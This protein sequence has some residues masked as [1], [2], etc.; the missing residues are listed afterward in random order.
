MSEK[1]QGKKRKTNK[2]RGKTC[3]NADNIRVQSDLKKRRNKQ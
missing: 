2:W 1:A 3:L